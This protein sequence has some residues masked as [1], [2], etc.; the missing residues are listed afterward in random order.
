[1]ITHAS[2]GPEAAQ[3]ALR[4]VSKA[5]GTRAVLDQVGFTVRPG[6]RVGVI[7]ENGS[8]KSTLLRLI[9][10]AEEP[11]G[12]E[13]RVRFPGGVAYL[14]Q[15]LD[16]DD[17]ARVQ[18]AV[19]VSLAGLRE[20]ERKLR[21][22]E[23]ALAGADAAALDAYGE[24]LAA[25]E[26]RGGYQADARVDAALHGLGVGTIGRERRL[27][28]LSGGE[29]S[30]VALACA[31]ASGAELLLLDEPTNHLDAAATGWLEARL[32]AHRGTVLAVTHDR[33]FL[34]SVATAIL[35]VDRDSRSVHRY[36][37]GFEGYRAA[38]AAARRRWVRRR[39]EYVDEVARTRELVEA[40]A[41]RL[42]TTGRDPR[43]GFGKHRRSSEA[44]LSGRVREARQRL[45]RLER[46]PVP[47]PPEPLTFTPR[48]EAA[49]EA[50]AVELAGVL[51][52]GRLWLD[53]LRVGSGDRLLVTGENG[54]GKSTLLRV[55]AGELAPDRGVVRR[56]AGG[57]VGY[58]P[59]ETPVRPT[60][61]PL[62]A[63]YAAGRPGT[64]EEYGD[65]LLALG[66]FR[67]EDLTVPVA[68]LSVGQRR[69]L[70]LARLVSRPADLLVLDEPTNHV[71]LSLVEELEVA[72]AA[73]RGAVV[74]VSHDR[75]F[76]DAFRGAEV[77]LR[78]GRRVS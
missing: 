69:R 60:G 22:A 65:E 78:G 5:Y 9:A 6:E 8:G 17:T 63:A 53:G 77:V 2:T 62:L 75:R 4:D 33:V 55:I 42:A 48:L 52:E 13:V 1:M 11:D 72:L 45:E 32:R 25:F 34:E 44:K 20:L 12:G 3:L 43:Q 76:R 58:L 59:Q 40:A 21:A 67:E 31:L 54:A 50:S 24:L 16:L 47:A 27:G 57:R 66:L 56:S 29:R 28:S 68:A 64:A 37:D 19:E 7:G 71:A 36:G 23:E 15:T 35:E 61:R 41:R 73:Y 51:V 30:R 49:E 38:K 18:D 39:E 26:E 10:G 46:E 70:E 14:E 74:V